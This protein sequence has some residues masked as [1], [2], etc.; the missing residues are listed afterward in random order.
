M[1]EHLAT[2]YIKN[3]PSY[4]NAF[5]LVEL[6]VVISIIAL[7]IS[8]LLPALQG[9]RAEARAVTCMSN[10]RQIGLG[11]HMYA[12]DSSG[13]IPAVTPDPPQVKYW[14]ELLSP[15]VG[16]LKHVTTPEGVWRCPEQLQP[17]IDMPAYLARSYGYNRQITDFSDG[18]KFLR[19]SDVEQ[20]V[21][22]IE[23]GSSPPEYQASRSGLG[24]AR[25]IDRRH[26]G[27]ANYLYTD[28]HVM[29]SGDD[30][31]IVGNIPGLHEP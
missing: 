25:H 17:H 9:A 7:M 12:N 24:F 29:R 5:T 23:Y 30:P 21:I 16:E 11:L 22:I 18:Q 8:I 26:S 19:L 15:Y 14:F 3:R 28:G 10:M 2:R 4:R 6:L 20:R 1:R 31:E 27:T 13:R